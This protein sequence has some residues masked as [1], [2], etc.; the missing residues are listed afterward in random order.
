MIYC[1]EHN[2]DIK[3]NKKRFSYIYENKQYNYYPDFIVNNE[4][5]EI[6]GFMN[7]KDKEKLK[8][9]PFV[10]VLFEEDIKYCFDY[11]YKKYNI[12]YKELKN[13]YN[14]IKS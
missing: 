4:Y 5:I 9:N 3:R 10:K 6:K 7:K 2:I 1:L 8:Q 14:G 13:L 12:K 11:V